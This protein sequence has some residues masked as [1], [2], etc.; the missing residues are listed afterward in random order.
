MLGM[1]GSAPQRGGARKFPA[2]MRT[3][4]TLPLRGTLIGGSGARGVAWMQY[5][6]MSG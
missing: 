6:E 4:A 3:V 1:H 5:G 2:R